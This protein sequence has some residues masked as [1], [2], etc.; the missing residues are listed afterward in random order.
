MGGCEYEHVSILVQQGIF[1]KR[2]FVSFEPPFLSALPRPPPPP[3]TKKRL[4]SQFLLFSV[5]ALKFSTSAVPPR[6]IVRYL[7]NDPTKINPKRGRAFSKTQKSAD[8]SP[9]KHNKN[10]NRIHKKT[11]KKKHRL[12]RLSS[13]STAVLCRCAI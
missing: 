3:P 10:K 5:K 9:S 6:P 7:G 1:R 13:I 11:N 2:S 8:F 12:C 4:Y